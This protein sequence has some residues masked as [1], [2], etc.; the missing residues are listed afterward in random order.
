MNSNN[1][2]INSFAGGVVLTCMLGIPVGFYYSIVTGAPLGGCII[3]AVCAVFCAAILAFEIDKKDVIFLAAISAVK[4]YLT[5]YQAMNKS[6]PMGGEDWFNF[7]NNAQEI[8]KQ[9]SSWIEILRVE[10]A[11]LFSKLVAVLYSAFGV[12]TMFINLFIL[13][14]SFGTA[15]FVYKASMLITDHDYNVSAKALFLFLLWPID[16]I[17]SVTYLRE[18]P[19]QMFVA[20]SFYFF[21][22]YIKYRDPVSL[23]IAFVSIACAS[24]MHS[25]VI[26]IIAVYVMFIPR[27]ERDTRARLFSP[28]NIILLLVALIALRFSPVWGSLSA[29]LG[30]VDTAQDLVNRSQQFNVEA[31]TQYVTEMPSSFTGF[32]L[33][34]PWRAALFAIVPLPWMINSS[35]TAFAWVIDAVPQIW[36]IYRLVVMNKKTMGLKQRVYYM[37]GVFSIIGTYIVCG[38]GTT[39]YGNAIRHRSK[40]FPI[41]VVLVIAIYDHI[42]KHGHQENE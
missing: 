3:G 11:D 32:I 27:S 5:M 20:M 34:T 2:I 26:A 4:I 16:I 15:F 13:A 42:R 29:K 30:D 28:K 39:A 12:H 33:Q 6:L 18:M 7:H 41:M 19:I 14:T 22:R 31:S 17:F 38:M 37:I 23:V 9:G 24:L 1:S 35:A 25:G 21:V 8:M 36:F 10:D 40:V